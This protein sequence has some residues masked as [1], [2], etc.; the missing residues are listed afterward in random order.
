MVAGR[1]SPQ[2]PT[3]ADGFPVSGHKA[4]IKYLPLP[5]L[6]K[7][8]DFTAFIEGWALYAERLMWELGAYDQDPYGNLGRLQYE[9]WRAAR[10]VVDTGINNQSSATDR[11]HWNF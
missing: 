8:G 5:L 6:R 4:F 3:H 1:V 10:L 9:A 11:C 7:Q 2:L